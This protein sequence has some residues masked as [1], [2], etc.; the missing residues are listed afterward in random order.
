[1]TMSCLMD[2]QPEDHQTPDP[3]PHDPDHRPDGADDLL[4]RYESGAMA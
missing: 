2:P 4:D 1:M 3:V